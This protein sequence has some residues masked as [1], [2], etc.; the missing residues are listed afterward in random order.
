MSLKCVQAFSLAMPQGMQDGPILPPP[1]TVPAADEKEVVEGAPTP[2]PE[3]ETFSSVRRA[4]ESHANIEDEVSDVAKTKALMLILGADADVAMRQAHFV[5]DDE[6][7]E[8][9]PPVAP[10]PDQ[11]VRIKDEQLYKIGVPNFQKD[12]NFN[13]TWVQPN[14]Y[15]KLSIR[16][17]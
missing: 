14:L 12:I 9:Q 5:E 6:P 16:I 2:P 1:S 15:L 11:D 10:C 3:E 13:S 8:S 7:K 4:E 17:L